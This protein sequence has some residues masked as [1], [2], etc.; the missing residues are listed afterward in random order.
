MR[1][2][3]ISLLGSIVGFFI[4][5]VLM[6]IFFAILIGA[7]ASS[8]GS[9]DKISSS[10]SVVLKMD[11]R[12]GMLDHGGENSFIGETPASLVTSIRALNRAKTDEKIKGL[13]IRANGW[14]MPP[15]HAEELRLAIIDFKSSGK[16]VV[17]H[18]QGFEGTS[19]SSYMAVSAA[20]EIWMQDTTGF[21]LAGYRAEVEFLGGVFEKYDVKA[22]FI[23][24]HEYKNAVN[25]YTEKTLTKPHREAMTALLQS[26]MDTSVSHMAV[27]RELP[28]AKILAFLDG[29]PPI[30]P[31]P[32]RRAVLLI[33]LVIMHLPVI[34]LRKKPA[35]TPPSKPLKITEP[36]LAL[37]PSSPLLAA[38]ARL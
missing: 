38:K 32:Q 2:F 7:V 30:A 21:A 19:L 29:M 11:L 16:F 37:A 34:T 23:Q 28:K 1:Q 18:A 8:V 15:E 14:S 6:F 13:F 36:R 5:M 4:A 17:A 12:G 26:L 9:K 35:K 3:F 10:K 20:D 24:F 33:N 22:D 31:K 25:S 27:D